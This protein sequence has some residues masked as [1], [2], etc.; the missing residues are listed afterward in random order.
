M[1]QFKAGSYPLDNGFI[2]S[3]ERLVG[4]EGN[5]SD[6]M[7]LVNMNTKS[8]NQELSAIHAKTDIDTARDRAVA[9]N[10][11]STIDHELVKLGYNR[12]ETE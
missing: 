12:L 10:G 11:V 5:W 2:R 6:R 4:T 3:I 9:S 8:D 7:I 1:V